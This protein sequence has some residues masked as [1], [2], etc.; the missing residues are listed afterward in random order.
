MDGR[1]ACKVGADPRRGVCRGILEREALP[2]TGYSWRPF[3][4]TSVIIAPFTRRH[5][6]LSQRVARGSHS[7]LISS[8][9]HAGL[10]SVDCG[11][12]RAAA[13][14]HPRRAARGRHEAGA[15]ADLLVRTSERTDWFELIEVVDASDSLHV[16]LHRR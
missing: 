13:N 10:R 16:V 4:S 1:I 11:R 7:S 9:A 14:F 8:P 6:T 15:D 2:W 5:L 3:D 12:A